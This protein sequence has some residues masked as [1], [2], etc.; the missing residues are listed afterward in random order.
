M[1]ALNVPLAS[2]V[3]VCTTA[4]AMPLVCIQFMR[5]RKVSLGG[6]LAGAI[7]TVLSRW[8]AVIAKV[9]YPLYPEG[10]DGD[11]DGDAGAVLL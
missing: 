3:T 7:V 10:G 8:T 5:T 9:G 1:V 2:V 11:G 4:P 6:K